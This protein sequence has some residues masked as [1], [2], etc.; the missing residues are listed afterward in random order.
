MGNGIRGT[1]FHAVT[2][3]NAPVVVDVVDLC[4]AFGARDSALRRVLGCLD[5]DTVGRAGCR[6]Q[7][8]GDTFLNAV[9]IPLQDMCTAETVLEVST[10]VW[11]RSVRVI[12]HL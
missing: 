4:I 6:A 1:S 8:T 5:I 11:A 3:K 10:A 9:L 12:F 2:A 7:E